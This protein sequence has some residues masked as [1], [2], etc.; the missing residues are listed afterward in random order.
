MVIMQ[1]KAEKQTNMVLFKEGNVRDP[2]G[3]HTL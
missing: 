2:L 1:N 3:H